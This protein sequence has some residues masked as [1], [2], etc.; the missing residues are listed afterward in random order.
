MSAQKTGQ[1]LPCM[2]C[3]EPFYRRRSYI[4][5]GI[6]KSCGKPECKSASMSGANNPFW[7]RTHDADTL[8]K[9]A[10]TKRARGGP[11]KRTGPPKGYQHT[12]EARA[13]ISE[14]LRQRWLNNREKMLA[15]HP[16]KLTPREEQRYRRNFTPLQRREWKAEAC[17]WCEATENLVLDH[18]IP[19][20]AGGTNHRANAQTLCQPCNIWKMKY[21][22]RP[23][24]LA[25]LGSEGGRD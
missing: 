1:T 6:R 13:K 2:I 20:M 19:V 22:D 5:R 23:F 10:N 25:K 9:I 17:V 15:N 14:A 11:K 8:A 4:E 24:L 16:P 12:P 7:G 21:V 18:I 3:G